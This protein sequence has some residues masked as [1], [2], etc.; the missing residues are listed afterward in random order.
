MSGVASMTTLFGTALRD[1]LAGNWRIERRID[2]RSAG[3]A[4]DFTGEAT[5]APDGPAALLYRE[6]GTLRSGG[7][8]LRATQSHRWTF[9][10]SSAEVAFADG[11]PFH[12]VAPVG[13]NAE[14]LHDCPP[15]LYRVRYRFETPER[16]RQTWHVTGP[17]KD[18]TLESL[19]TRLRPAALPVKG[20]RD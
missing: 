8:A 3:E 5:F 7:R 20:P 19:F 13:R 17:R 15:D 16:W 11:R 9:T 14:A 18:Y 1:W 10:A 12:A 4:S 2:D 6:S